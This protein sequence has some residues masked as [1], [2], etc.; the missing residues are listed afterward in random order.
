MAGKREKATYSEKEIHNLLRRLFKDNN[1]NYKSNIQKEAL[2]TIINRL[3]PFIFYIS[4]TSSGKSLL[5]LLPSFIRN[6]VLGFRVSR[7]EK[8]LKVRPYNYDS[9]ILIRTVI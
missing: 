5:F 6:R 8:P 1:T 4:P 2:Y 3:E 7:L 9:D